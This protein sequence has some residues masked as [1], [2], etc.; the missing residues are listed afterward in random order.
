MKY[1]QDK[2][3]YWVSYDAGA[4]D[5]AKK[6]LLVPIG[7][8][9]TFFKHFLLNDSKLQQKYGGALAAIS[10]TDASS[11]PG[12]GGAHDARDNWLSF[13]QDIDRNKNNSVSMIEFEAGLLS[14]KYPDEVRRL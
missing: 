7:D 13:Y 4:I 9:M 6:N 2:S 8:E 5:A 10:T 11:T 14:M 12:G 1:L 3:T